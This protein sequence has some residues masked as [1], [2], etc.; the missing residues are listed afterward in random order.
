MSKQIIYSIKPIKYIM[1]FPFCGVLI[2]FFYEIVTKGSL[3]LFGGIPVVTFFFYYFMYRIN[4]SVLLT[5]NELW[6]IFNLS[7]KKIVFNL[8]DIQ[9]INFTTS[10]SMYN[11]KEM[12]IYKE[13]KKIRFEHVFPLQETI[14]IINILTNKGIKVEYSDYYK[15]N[16]NT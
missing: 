14:N 12:V 4:K 1:Y 15:V 2:V 13:E 6:V 7:G 16:I 10:G 8:K 9:K 3:V 11:I 5:E